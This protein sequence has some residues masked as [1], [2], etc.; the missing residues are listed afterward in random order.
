MQQGIVAPVFAQASGA[1]PHA[2][3]VREISHPSGDAGAKTEPGAFV[4][5]ARATAIGGAA[6]AAAVSVVAVGRIASPA[7]SWFPS[8]PELHR[9]TQAVQHV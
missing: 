5:T 9:P 4:A 7:V 6:L 3:R 1:S 2:D 8:P